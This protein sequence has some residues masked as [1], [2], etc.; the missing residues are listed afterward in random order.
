MLVLSRKEG[1]RIRIGKDIFIS[2][3][4][5]GTDR[6]RFGIEAPVDMPILRD[7]LE[8]FAVSQQ[9]NEMDCVL[10]PFQVIPKRA[11]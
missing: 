11:S 4:H 10:L 6:V 2:V 5:T 7:E 9:T 8:S 1:E 3:I